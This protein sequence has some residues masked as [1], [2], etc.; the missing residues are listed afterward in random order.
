MFIELEV[1]QVEDSLCRN[2]NMVK[3]LSHH[4]AKSACVNSY[5][6]C[7]DVCYLNK[8]VVV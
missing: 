1:H 2:A 7:N 5:S 8:C 4:G 3:D 6:T